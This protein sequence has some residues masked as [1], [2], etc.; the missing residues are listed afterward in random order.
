MNKKLIATAVAATFAAPAAMADIT[1][2][3][4]INNAL[5]WQDP[6]GGDSTVDLRNV[7]S[8]FGMRGEADLGNGIM[9]HGRYEFS[10]FTD[11]EGAGSAS[12]EDTDGDGVLD[13]FTGGTGRGGINDTRIGTVGISG[14]SWGRIDAGNQWSAYFNSVGTHMS[15]SYSLGYYLYSSIGGGPFRASNT[16]KYSHSWGPVSFELD[17]RF[18]QDTA[19]VEKIGGDHGEDFLDGYG[20]GIS[21]AATPDFTIAAA[22]DSELFDVGDDTDRV[23][24]GFSW[25]FSPQHRIAGG[26]QN[27]DT[28]AR[29]DDSAILFYHG[30][31]GG[32]NSWSVGYGKG[33]E[34][35]FDPSLVFLAFY[36]NW[37]EG[38]RSYV[39]AV[40]LDGDNGSRGD[41]N[42][43]I[44]GLRYDF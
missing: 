32:A 26:W 43:A 41:Q 44:F 22:I 3:A 24:L 11:R 28:G 20:I 17:T 35:G 34:G 25:S 21:I 16:V 36:H 2:Y 5:D 40:A 8:R 30:N 18:S 19:D 37:G 38:F 9:V 33:E 10:T 23:A 39:E 1:V 42:Q 12:A 13:T 27:I 29:D 14:E 15:P 7:S 31:D 6:D 4:R